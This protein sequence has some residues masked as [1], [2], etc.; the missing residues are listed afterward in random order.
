MN[1]FRKSGVH[2]TAMQ[3]WR[4]DLHQ[5]IGLTTINQMDCA[6]RSTTVFAAVMAAQR[7]LGTL[8]EIHQISQVG[9]VNSHS[10]SNFQRT[11][12]HSR[13]VLWSKENEPKVLLLASNRFGDTLHFQNYG[14]I[15]KS[16]RYEDC[17]TKSVFEWAHDY[18]YKWRRIFSNHLIPFQ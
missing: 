16:P 15:V 2:R 17:V 11:H 1:T 4:R 14:L 8:V 10:E 9:R 12:N 7:R 6:H 13:R 18:K 3:I 5:V